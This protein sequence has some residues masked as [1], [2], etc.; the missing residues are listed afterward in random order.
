MIDFNRD[1]KINFKDYV[2]LADNFGRTD[3]MPR[4]IGDLGAYADTKNYEF[5]VSQTLMSLR[6]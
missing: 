4:T 6:Y 1:R 5:F 3:T 2:I